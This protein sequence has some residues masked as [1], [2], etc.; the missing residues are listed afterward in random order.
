VESTA[1][2]KALFP[3][4]FFK[5]LNIRTIKLATVGCA[6]GELPSRQIGIAMIIAARLGRRGIV[7]FRSS[8][9]I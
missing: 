8:S 1:L 2:R 9:R 5:T 4:A 3:L 7:S 6:I